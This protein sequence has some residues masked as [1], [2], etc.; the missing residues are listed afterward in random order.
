MKRIFAF[1]FLTALLTLQ[2]CTPPQSE[3]DVQAETSAIRTVLE[4]YVIA[5]ENEDISIIEEIWAPD[6]DIMLIGTDSDEFYVGWEAI[7]KAIQ[8]QFGSFENTL[9]SVTD[10]KIQLDKTGNA[11]WFSEVLN[12]NFIYNGE[13]ISFE[14]IRFTGVLEKRDLKWLLVQ[15]HLSIPVE[16][17]LEEEMV[18]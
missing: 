7:K 18:R 16:V 12:Y 1:V 3:V 9:I 5:R 11:A 13:A 2:F 17:E 8:G 6:E 4:K 10:Q 15:G 14:G